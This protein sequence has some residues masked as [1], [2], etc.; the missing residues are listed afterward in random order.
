MTGAG[1][2]GEDPCEAYCDQTMAHCPALYP[3]RDACLIGCGEIRDDGQWD[4]ER[5]N[6]VSCRANYASWPAAQDM[7]QCQNASIGSAECR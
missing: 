3:S 1:V 2:C 4:D 5:G 6:T 7:A